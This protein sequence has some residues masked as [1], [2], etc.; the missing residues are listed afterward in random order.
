MVFGLF[1]VESQRNKKQIDFEK[2]KKDRKQAI[3]YQLTLDKQKTEN[4]YTNI[5]LKE[6]NEIIEQI[7]DPYE[8]GF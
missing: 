1:N 6:K 3:K 4:K 8:N 2:T 5:I 7:L